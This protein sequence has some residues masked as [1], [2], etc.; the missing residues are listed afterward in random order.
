MRLID[1]AIADSSEYPWIG[2]ERRPDLHRG[3]ADRHQLDG[4]KGV[5]DASGSD[6]GH[7]RKGGSNVRHSANRDRMNRRAREATTP[8]AERRPEGGRIEGETEQGVHQGESLSTRV[9][10][11]ACHLDDPVGIGT[12]L[13][14]T[15]A[16]AALRCREH[17]SGQIGVVGENPASRK[18]W[19]I[20]SAMNTERCFPPVQP[21][22]MWT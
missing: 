3:C 14:P 20:C 11:R 16:S 18:P 1:Q 12:Q 4:V 13:R 5:R 7:V 21:K 19:A 17:L 2:E 8:I 15:R 6:D 22:A 10:Y 9:G